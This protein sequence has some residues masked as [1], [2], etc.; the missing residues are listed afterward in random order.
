MALRDLT[1]AF[2]TDAV[3]CEVDL[4]VRAGEVMAV[5]GDNGSGKTM[6]AS[7][8]AGMIPPTSGTIDVADGIRVGALLDQIVVPD[9]MS[10]REHLL[11][12]AGERG[13][14]EDRVEEVL[15]AF[16]LRDRAADH[17]TSWS[18]GMRARHALAAVMLDD[19]DVLIADEPDRGLDPAGM[20]WLVGAL[21]MIARAGVGIVLTTHRFDALDPAL[22]RVVL[23]D[24]GR[25]IVDADR[26]GWLARHDRTDLT[27]AVMDGMRALPTAR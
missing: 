16:G 9:V 3:L 22:E 8:L 10:G 7:V 2:G 15:D 12:V 11:S 1:L 4:D 5:V 19:P 26:A 21:Q 23:I 25:V 24:R 14:G 20:A 6:L 13:I 17:A 18:R 27:D